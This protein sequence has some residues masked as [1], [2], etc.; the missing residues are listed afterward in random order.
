MKLGGKER[1]VGLAT[2]SRSMNLIKI[3]CTKILKAL[4]KKRKALFS[5]CLTSEYT[6]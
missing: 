6:N 3:E 4:I 2:V 1:V 5:W